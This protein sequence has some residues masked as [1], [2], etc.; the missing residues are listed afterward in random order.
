VR[1]AEPDTNIVIVEL[2]DPA[3]DPDAVVAGLETRGVWMTTFGRGRLRAITHLD[4]DDAGLAR[5]V[6]AF[7]ET[8][9]ARGLV[10]R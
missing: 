8:V 6:D 9:E 3:L 7:R 2:V 4:V 1:V 5:A 10:R